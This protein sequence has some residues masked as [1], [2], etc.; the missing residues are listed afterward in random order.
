MN[1]STI[2]EMI[3]WLAGED[4]AAWYRTLCDIE[5]LPVT[6]EVENH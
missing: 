4:R 5:D 6:H 3:F 2:E 1:A